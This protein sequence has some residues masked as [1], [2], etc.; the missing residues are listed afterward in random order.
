M[1]SETQFLFYIEKYDT[2]KTVYKYSMIVFDND[3][4]VIKEI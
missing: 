3:T 4:W 1:F 2:N